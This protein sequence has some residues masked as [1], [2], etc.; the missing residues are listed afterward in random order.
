[1]ALHAN[2]IYFTI[3]QP[4]GIFSTTPPEKQVFYEFY[5]IYFKQWSMGA[6]TACPAPMRYLRASHLLTGNR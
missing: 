3:N 1:M 5:C 4:D 6:G 2:E